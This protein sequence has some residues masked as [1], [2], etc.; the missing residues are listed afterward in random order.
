VRFSTRGAQKHFKK[1]K[2]FG[3]SPCPC[4]KLF[5]ICFVK[6]KESRK[7]KYSCHS[8]PSIS[9]IAFLAASLHKELKN[10]INIFSKTRPKNLQKKAGR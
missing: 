6:V 4:Q 5:V 1:K 9:F 2:R 10:T 8:F 7:K 3:E